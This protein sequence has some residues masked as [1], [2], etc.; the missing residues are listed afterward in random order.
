[1]VGGRTNV[2]GRVSLRLSDL[3]LKAASFDG[4]G[5]DWPLAYKDSHPITTWWKSTL[6]W[7]A[8]PKAIPICR[9]ESFNRQCRYVARRPISVTG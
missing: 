6:A 3:D 8:A 1:M 4:Y 5:A 2:W 7:P 9:T